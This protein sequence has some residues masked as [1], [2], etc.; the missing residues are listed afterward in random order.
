MTTILFCCDE[1]IEIHYPKIENVI[2]YNIDSILDRGEEKM[3]QGY[4]VEA[5]NLFE[6]AI[7]LCEKNNSKSIRLCRA[8]FNCSISLAALNHEEQALFKIGLLNKILETY[9]CSNARK[10]NN[11]SY[12][13]RGKPILGE[14]EI[15]IKECLERT[16]NSKDLALMIIGLAPI[17]ANIK[18]ALTSALMITVNRAKNCC[19][20]GGVWKA[21]L[22]PLLQK[23]WDLKMWE[24]E[25]E[26]NF[27]I[28]PPCWD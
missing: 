12:S 10:I 14:D 3:L 15:S 2:E 13:V 27:Q 5:N 4:F 16:E 1:D 20:L 11:E 17:P 22:Q 9:Q 24:Q 6:N 18:I 8:F 7:E 19:R 23:W 21:C 26:R 28:G 25:W